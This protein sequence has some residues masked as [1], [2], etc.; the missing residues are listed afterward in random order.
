[1]RPPL[2]SEA[3]HANVA[4][5]AGQM[6]KRWRRWVEIEDLTQE[7]WLEYYRD[8]REATQDQ[9]DNRLYNAGRR[10][11]RAEKARQCG[12]EP[13]DE[14]YYSTRVIRELL[15]D[16]VADDPPVMRGQDEREVRRAV[17]GGIVSTMEYET[18]L[19]DI[20][21]AYDSMPTEQK[22][23]VWRAYVLQQP[24]AQIAQ[25]YGDVEANVAKRCHRGLLRMQS[26]LGGRRPRNGGNNG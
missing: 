11:C 16:V 24:M 8:T 1:M 15:P 14:A 3:A 13:D 10:Y 5:I 23:L 6:Y 22:D 2:S 7:L 21:R 20:K 9:L 25:R 19:I 17:Q 26:F 4:I 18:A 12:Y